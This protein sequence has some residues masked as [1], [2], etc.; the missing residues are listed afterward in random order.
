MAKP[1]NPTVK[2]QNHTNPFDLSQVRN[3]D[4]VVCR[5]VEKF[6]ETRALVKD[7]EFVPVEP[8]G[9]YVAVSYK[10]IDGG[11]LGIYFDP[12]EM[13]LV[14]IADSFGN[15][16]MS[17]LVPTREGL[18]AEDFRFLEEFP[19]TRELLRL[20]GVGSLP[21]ACQLLNSSRNAMQ[22]AEYACIFERMARYRDEPVILMKD[23]L[24][25]NIIFKPSVKAR[26]Y[27]VLREFPKQKLVGVAKRSKV[28]DFTSAALWAEGVVQQDA[29]GYVEIPLEIEREVYRW[30]QTG[31]LLQYGKLYVAKL[32]PASNLLVTVEIPHDHERGVA[33]YGRAEIDEIFGHLVRD[34]AYSFPTIGYPQTIMRAHE[35]AVATGFSA[36]V[37]RDLI[38]EELLH[39]A[40]DPDVQNHF[41]EAWLLK[42][43][44]K[45][46]PLGG[47]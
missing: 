40:G 28:L 11:K 15:E 36:S 31:N 47:T 35:K 26:V 4:S 3:L 33:I 2:Y 14:Q 38:M 22:V 10:S 37:W 44:V 19:E 43:Y 18:E 12:F 9:N 46:H 16:P 24:L 7:L 42:Q 41:R 39:R 1:S 8:A 20:L 5:Q 13:D 27:D 30:R 34:S 32:S 45:Q 29:A 23:G 17:F 6:N 25:R 21:E